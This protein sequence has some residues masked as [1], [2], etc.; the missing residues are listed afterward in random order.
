MESML[1]K[2]GDEDWKLMMRMSGGLEN[3]KEFVQKG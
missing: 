1:Q 3:D 2:K